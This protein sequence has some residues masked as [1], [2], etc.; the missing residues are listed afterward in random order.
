[1]KE[2]ILLIGPYPPPSGGVS[3]HILRLMQTFSKDLDFDL[4][5]ESRVRSRGGIFNLRSMNLIQYFAKVRHS[6]IV[7]IHS[8]KSILRFIHFVIASLFGKHIII[9]FHSYRRNKVKLMDKIAA[10]KAH[11]LVFVNKTIAGLFA[12]KGFIKDAFLPPVLNRESELPVKIKQWV[13]SLKSSGFTICCGNAWKLINNNGVDLYG[14]DMCIHACKMLKDKGFKLAVVFVVSNTSSGDY[15]IN[16]YLALIKKYDIED[17]FLLIQE[18][19]SFIRL[20]QLS[21]IILRPT[22]SDGDALT[23]REGLWLNKPVLASDAVQRPS[24]VKLFKNRDLTSFSQSLTELLENLSSA[25][26][27]APARQED[28]SDFYLNTLYT[29][30]Q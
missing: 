15:D 1:M 30:D 11:K 5:D 16:D 25:T 22:N 21:D 9:T 7:H 3:T 20:I 28:I 26:A 19:I 12:I 10:R 2:K 13:T 18:P 8:G 6:E 24:S 4:I 17:R 29:I 14:L 27:T 23:V